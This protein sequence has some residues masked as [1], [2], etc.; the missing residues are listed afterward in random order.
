MAVAG[1]PILTALLLQLGFGLKP[2]AAGLIVFTGAAGAL[3]MKAAAEPLLRRFGF[4]RVLTANAF[5]TA[6][7]TASYA[8]FS[9]ATPHLLIIAALFAGGFFRSLQYTSLGTLAHADL[10]DEAMSRVSAFASMTQEIAQS[11]GTSLAV[12]LVHGL[13]LTSGV[14]SPGAHEIRLAFPVVAVPGLV[15]AAGFPRLH[16]EDRAA[17]RGLIQRG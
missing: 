8:L 3:L 14:V 1:I 16:D 9:A 17:L 13:M 10:T 7:F 12:L 15:A 6:A 5:V 4:R 11:I 2:L